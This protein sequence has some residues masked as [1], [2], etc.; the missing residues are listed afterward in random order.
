MIQIDNNCY[1]KYASCTALVA[2]P[3]AK[4]LHTWVSHR[5]VAATV[6]SRRV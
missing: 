4:I 1:Q 6:C 3:V 2:R 5:Y